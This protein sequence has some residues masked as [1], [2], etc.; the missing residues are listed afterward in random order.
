MRGEDQNQYRF[1][2]EFP[3]S[4]PHARGRPGRAPL[5]RPALDAA[6]PGP[7]PDHPRMRGEDRSAPREMRSRDG[8]PPHARGRRSGLALHARA[9]G[10]TPACAGK[11]AAS[12][13][14][15][16]RLTDHPRMRGEDVNKQRTR[17][18]ESGSPPHARGRLCGYVAA[19]VV[20][21]ITPACAGK[22]VTRRVLLRQEPDHPR[23]RGEDDEMLSTQK[24]KL[25][26][27]PHARGRR[28]P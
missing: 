3:G 10:I 7:L 23:M 20:S 14:R 12:T 26:S 17:R 6:S 13:S 28:K 4:P 24:I 2:S 27:P 9:N 15:P 8:S 19:G 25:G 16:L 18:A 5:P 21:G 11:T 1:E 22:T